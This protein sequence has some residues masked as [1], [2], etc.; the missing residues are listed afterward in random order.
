[1]E[2]P[3]PVGEEH[4]FSSSELPYIDIDKGS[5]WF[6]VSRVRFYLLQVKELLT[7]SKMTTLDISNFFT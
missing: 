4:Q 1:M 2:A 5:K 7:T 3:E 6:N